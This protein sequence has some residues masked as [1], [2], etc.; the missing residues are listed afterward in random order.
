MV[1]PRPVWITRARPG[2]DATAGRLRARGHLPLIGPLLQVRLLA[3]TEL[4]T[5]PPAALAFT[6]ANAMRA[7]AERT[8]A[9]TAP[10]FAVGAATAHAARTAGFAEVDCADGD[11]AALGLR[12]IRAA[13]NG[14]VLHPCA[15]E[16]AG[17]LGGVLA[18]AG[19]RYT[20]LALTRRS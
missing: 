8:T 20:R 11:V 19:V 18:A 2:A 14:T 7:F 3:G 6:S 4:A 12:I 5:E 13:P 10:V 17:D 1:E 15:S 16:A 9:R